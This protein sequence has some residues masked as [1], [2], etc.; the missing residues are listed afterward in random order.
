MSTRVAV[1]ASLRRLTGG[2]A[3]IEGT[4]ATVH[5]L[6]TDLDSRHPGLKAKLYDDSGRIQKFA[7]VFINGRDIRTLQGGDTALTGNEEINIVTAIAGG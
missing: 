1:P 6:F 4:G 5:A 3:V 7:A 2:N